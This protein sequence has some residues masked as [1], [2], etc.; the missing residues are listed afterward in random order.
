VDRSATGPDQFDPDPVRLEAVPGDRLRVSDASGRFVDLTVVG[1]LEQTLEFTSGVFADESI[2]R[3]TF[4]PMNLY[5]AYFFQ[6]APGVD[7]RALRADLERV[8]F[9]WGLQTI[10]IREE[11]GEA[12]DASQQ[13]LT[14][15]QVYLGIGLL[16]GIAGLVVVT[17]RAV[18]ERRSQIGTM[19]AIGFTRRMVLGVFLAEIAL[20]AVLGI[21]IG[22]S[23]G[24]VFAWKVHTVYFADVVVFA[25]PWDHLA[26]IVALASAAAIAST[27][28]P[29]VRASRIPPAEA[30]RRPE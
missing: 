26:L 20:V 9:V 8:F 1:V 25:V 4:P 16:V 17:L 19:R 12:Y 2:V 14:L 7:V 15:M 5:T 13:V 10:D 29:A 24:V 30:L 28:H 11:I 6:V 21:A 3:S 18:V 22:V 27:A 23:L